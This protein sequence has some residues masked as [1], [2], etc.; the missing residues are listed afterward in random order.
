MKPFK[1]VEDGEIFVVEGGFELKRVSESSDYNAV[2]TDSTG[3]GV[4][5]PTDENTYTVDEFSKLPKPVQEVPFE[6][7]Y[8]N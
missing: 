7:S 6:A 1:D 3:I 5:I 8:P 2:F 4:K